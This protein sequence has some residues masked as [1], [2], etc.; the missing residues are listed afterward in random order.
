MRR[1]RLRSVCGGHRDFGLSVRSKIFLCLP[2]R[3]EFE[4]VTMTP[5]LIKMAASGG[6]KLGKLV[7]GMKKTVEK[8]IHPPFLKTNIPAGQA[9]PAPPLGTQLGQVR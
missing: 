3:V 8:V 5:H 4:T 7:K 2:I 1:L 6:K 9:S